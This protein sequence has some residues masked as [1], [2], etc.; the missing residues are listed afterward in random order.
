MIEFFRV[1][2]KSYGIIAFAPHLIPSA[3][4]LA[5]TF[6]NPVMGLSGVIG[7]VISNLTGS[8]LHPN[9]EVFK[10]GVFGINGILFGIALPKYTEMDLTAIVYLIIGAIIT[11]LVSLAISVLL[12]KIDIPVLSIPFT[13]VFWL[14][15][16]IIGIGYKGEMEL[17][18]LQFMKSMDLW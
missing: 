18:P 5:A 12:E 4:L 6:F 10:S 8:W 13:V 17:Q 15:V 3:I 1:C 2:L 11:G 16:Y 9:K 14:F 7:N